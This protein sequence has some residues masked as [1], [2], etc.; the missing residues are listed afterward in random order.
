MRIVFWGPS[1]GIHSSVIRTGTTGIVVKADLAKCY[2]AKRYGKMI[3]YPYN[4]SV[5]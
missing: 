1:A 3:P 5:P 2:S 4:S